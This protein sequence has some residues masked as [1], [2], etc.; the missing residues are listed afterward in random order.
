MF[1]FKSSEQRQNF[2]KRIATLPGCSL[3]CVIYQAVEA[4]LSLSS[5]K[6][7]SEKV[8]VHYSLN[9]SVKDPVRKQ[10]FV[11]VSLRVHRVPLR[12][13]VTGSLYE[14][15]SNVYMLLILG[16][17][18]GVW[19]AMKRDTRCLVVIA[20]VACRIVIKAKRT[21][22]S[23]SHPLR[24]LCVSVPVFLREQSVHRLLIVKRKTVSQCN[25]RNSTSVLQQ[26][27][28]ELVVLIVFLC[29][30]RHTLFGC[31]WPRH[32]R[33][34]QPVQFRPAPVSWPNAESTCSLAA[35]ITPQRR[36][37]VG[38]AGPATWLSFPLP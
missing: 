7:V 3:Y 31:G 16:I 6:N 14:E 38:F 1:R 12:L 15:K 11:L 5:D 4:Y 24:T 28:M 34:E 10:S 26:N 29:A 32:A 36:E 13:P 9:C 21:Y 18:L 33:Q 35:F 23:P 27:R 37:D 8:N 25:S 22:C 20:N 19:L 2:G 30:A 17:A